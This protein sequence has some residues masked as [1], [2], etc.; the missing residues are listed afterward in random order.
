MIFER[1]KITRR[2]SR[3][4]ANKSTPSEETSDEDE[5]NY[6]GGSDG[7]DDDDDDVDDGDDGGHAKET[8]KQVNQTK[9]P[10]PRQ[11][12]KPSTGETNKR[13]IKTWN[14]HEKQCVNQL[15]AVLVA[16]DSPESKTEQR[17]QVISTRMLA[18]Y[19]VER[20]AGSIKNYWNRTGRQAT[21]LD[22]RGTKAPDRM[23]TGK[24][25]AAKRKKARQNKKTK[26]PAGKSGSDED[27]GEPNEKEMAEPDEL[28]QSDDKV[29][30][31]EGSGVQYDNDDDDEDDEEDIPLAKRRR[32]V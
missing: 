11:P 12:K 25:D 18:Q 3:P 7:D 28:E 5:D 13:Q 15:M 8:P 29:P 6:K 31:N 22:E 1:K 4:G 9:K 30:G 17:W 32:R 26:T 16:E 27:K 24:Q 20:S 21:G 14:D 2:K 23:V 10:V 19:G